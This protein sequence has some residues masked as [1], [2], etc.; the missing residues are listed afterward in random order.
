MMK[1][2]LFLFL[3]MIFATSS[4]AQALTLDWAVRMGGTETDNGGAITVDDSGNVYTI[5]SFFGTVDFDPGSGTFDL[6]SAG[7]GDIF[8]SK[9]DDLGNFVWAVRMGGM[10][11][12]DGRS[13]AVDDAG[14][15]YAT[16]RF[17]G[18]A[19]FDPGPGIFN[20]TAVGMDDIYICKLDASGNFLWA[21]QIG[22]SSFDI[23]QSLALDASGNVIST[24]YFFGTADFDPGTGTANLTAAGSHD[25]YISKLDSDGNYIWAK[26]LGGLNI[27]FGIALDLDDFGNIYTTG[28]F[29]ETADF[30]PGAGTYN[31]TS[32][33]DQDI[34]VSKLDASGNFLWAKQLGGTGSDGGQSLTVDASGNVFTVGYFAD[35]GDF[36]PGVGT[37]NLTSFGGSDIFISKLNTSGDFV[38]AKQMGGAGFDEPLAVKI[39]GSGNLYTAGGFSDTADFDPGTGTFE[40]TTIGLLDIFISKLDATGN[41]AWATQF[42]STNSDDCL[43]IA[44][45][46]AGNVHSTG[47]FQNTADFD[48]GM[49]TLDLTSE[50]GF[51]IYIQKLRA[52]SVS[53]RENDL[54]ST[55]KIFPNPTTGEVFLDFTSLSNVSFRVLSTEGKVILKNANASD[56]EQFE[57]IG[58]PGIYFIEITSTEGNAVFKLVKF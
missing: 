58:S 33:G 12:D 43:A 4:F 1:N 57:L 55:I 53:T 42:G 23:G 36:D 46:D 38:W 11:I 44:V 51:D 54:F 5:G 22:D 41:F 52:A 14:N 21:K 29:R 27:D 2:L 32:A 50:G 15:I 3:S 16:G 17:G 34:F 8:I 49:G 9:L 40:L 39:D 45:D 18:T 19:D 28:H 35:T 20:L 24:G 26:Q 37:F 30:D 25:I 56:F 6:T 10:E 47:Y 48:P 7:S 31:L 13:I